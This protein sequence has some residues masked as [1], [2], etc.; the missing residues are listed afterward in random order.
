M[1]TSGFIAYEGSEL[2]YRQWGHGPRALVLFHGFGQSHQ[3]FAPWANHL[4]NDYTLYAFDLYFHGASTWPLRRPVSQ[5]DWDRIFSLFLKRH[6][7]GRFGIGAF[8]LGARFALVTLAGFGHQIDHLILLAPDGIKTNFWYRVATYPTATRAWF[9][10]MIHKPGRL[11]ALARLL[12]ILRLAD[13]GLIRFAEH[14]MNTE[15]K[16]RQVYCAWVYFRHLDVR[17][18]HLRQKILAHGTALLVITGTHDR[19]VPTNQIHP[20]FEGVS[21]VRLEELPCGHHELPTKALPLLRD[22]LPEGSQ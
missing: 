2:H 9:K 14:Q 10:S 13:R 16:R 4:G 15:E 12:R 6:R 3:A 18:R 20:F 21:A 7:I 22:W 1:E 11:T 8:S 19:L 17:P 5:Q